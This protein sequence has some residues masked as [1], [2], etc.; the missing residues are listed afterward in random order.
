MNGDSVFI[1][2]PARSRSINNASCP[3]KR[4]ADGRN[5]TMMDCLPSISNAYPPF[6]KQNC[7][8]VASHDPTPKHHQIDVAHIKS[9][10]TITGQA[11]SSVTGVKPLGQRPNSGPPKSADAMQQS[12]GAQADAQIVQAVAHA[13]PKS[14]STHHAQIAPAFG[15]GSEQRRAKPQQSRDGIWV[16]RDIDRQLTAANLLR[17]AMRPTILIMC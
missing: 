7:G 12:N 11:T 17:A 4:M 1:P 6:T 16:I 14:A 5:R 13:K 10:I 15:D 2:D 8:P 9:Q 3:S